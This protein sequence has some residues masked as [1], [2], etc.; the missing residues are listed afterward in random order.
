MNIILF[1]IAAVILIYWIR[2]VST[3]R[4]NTPEILRSLFGKLLIL[5]IGI[6]FIILGLII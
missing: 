5:G 2:G 4:L 3:D 6:I 1:I